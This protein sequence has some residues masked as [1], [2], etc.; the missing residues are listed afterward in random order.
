MK[1]HPLIS[2]YNQMEGLQLTPEVQHEVDV[3]TI[4]QK[5]SPHFQSF[6]PLPLVPEVFFCWEERERSSK[7]KPLV[8]GDANLII[9]FSPT[10]EQLFAEPLT[11]YHLK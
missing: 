2:L 6:Q 3:K 9:I 10:G 5:S 8:A 11:T 7:R 1:A 4:S